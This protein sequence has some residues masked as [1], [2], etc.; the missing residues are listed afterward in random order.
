MKNQLDLLENNLLFKYNT[1]IA[2][3]PH[4]YE[5]FEKFTLDAINAGAKK[6]SGWLV[7]NRLRWEVSFSTQGCFDTDRNYKIGNDY[8]AFLVRDFIQRNPQHK[9]IFTVKAMKR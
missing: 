8:I 7:V 3:N 5:L 6:L 9:K 4:V 1:W 2:A